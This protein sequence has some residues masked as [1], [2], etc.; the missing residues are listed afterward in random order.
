MSAFQETTNGL[1]TWDLK[2]FES[3]EELAVLERIK[4][5]IHNHLK[6]DPNN[7]NDSYLKRRIQSRMFY[8]QDT[9]YNDYLNRLTND[10]NEQKKLLDKLTVNV[11]RFF[12][13]APL[14]DEIG[15][16]V[17]PE[18]V[19]RKGKDASIRVWCAGCASGEEP[20]SV[21]ILFSEFFGL[22]RPPSNV[23]IFATDISSEAI[24]KAIMGEYTV[25]QLSETRS[26]I[27]SKYFR[28]D[29]E[30]YVIRDRIKHSVKF[31]EHDLFVDEPVKDLDIIMCRNVVIYFTRTAK[32]KLYMTFYNCLNPNGYYVIGKSETL[33]GEARQKFSFVNSEE[34]IYK[35]VE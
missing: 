16:V 3:E 28:R 10:V 9:S 23:Q 30:Y 18:I 34:K 14:W 24:N 32:E 5:F 26:D 4:E 6:F 33:T 7:Y 12:R 2:K 17:I 31:F 19:E 35:R 27:I 22:D 20:Y 11:T 1:N 29:E 25:T 13:N 8:F 15:N 21:A